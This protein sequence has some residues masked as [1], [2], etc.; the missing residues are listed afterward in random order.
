VNYGQIVTSSN[1]ADQQSAKINLDQVPYVNGSGKGITVPTLLPVGQK[2]CTSSDAVLS[3]G[4]NGCPNNGANF[5]SVT[6]TIGGNR[7]ITMGIH[8]TF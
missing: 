5:G 6:G 4:V 7:A 3:N 8:V 1:P 2:S